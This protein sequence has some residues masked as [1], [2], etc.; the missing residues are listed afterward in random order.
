[1]YLD[2]VWDEP[3]W[4]ISIFFP[5]LLSFLP[6]LFKFSYHPLQEVLP[7]PGHLS[8]ERKSLVLAK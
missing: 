7:I 3:K 8:R 1:M 5:L 4:T 6:D 2:H